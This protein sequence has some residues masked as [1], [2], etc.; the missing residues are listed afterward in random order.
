VKK[1]ESIKLLHKFNVLLL[2]DQ[3]KFAAPKSKALGFSVKKQGS[4][5]RLGHMLCPQRLTSLCFCGIFL[6]K[7]SLSPL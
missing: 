1:G 5:Q 4:F 2:A 6:I 7:K 3:L